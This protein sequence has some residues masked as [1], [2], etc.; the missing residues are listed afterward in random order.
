LKDAYQ[1]LSDPVERAEYDRQLGLEQPEQVRPIAQSP[2][3]L[4]RDFE[5]HTP[6]VEEIVETFAKNF[7]GRHQPKAVHAHE[8]NVEVVLTPAEASRG[9]SI[10]LGVPVFK[11]CATCAGTGRTGSARCD[12]CDGHGSEQVT[13]RI[14][15]LVPART[16]DGT[17]IPV[18]LKHLGIKNLYLRVLVRVAG[19]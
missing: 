4:I 9:G 18:S 8:L 17:A 14:D 15:V 2:M 6:S 11:P 19:V 5:R 1:A 12:V 16:A 7:T 3:D 13:A 10:P